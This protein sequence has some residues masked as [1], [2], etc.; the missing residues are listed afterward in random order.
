MSGRGCW[1]SAFVFGTT[2]TAPPDAAAKSVH[3]KG[4]CADV[5]SGGACTLGN[6]CAAGDLAQR[7][8]LS[9]MHCAAI[10]LALSA[11]QSAVDGR[12]LPAWQLKIST[13]HSACCKQLAVLQEWPR[14]CMTEHVLYDLSYVGQLQHTCRL[15]LC[16][17]APFNRGGRRRYGDTSSGGLTPSNG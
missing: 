7:L 3:L 12:L 5:P 9:H 2:G 16:H 6:S 10:T 17:C 1:L 4:W 8:R 13:V 15:A 11:C 14:H